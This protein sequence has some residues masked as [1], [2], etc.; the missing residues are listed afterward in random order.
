M[1][2]PQA[3][4]AARLDDL[5]TRIAHQDRMLAEMNEVITAQWDKID[6]LERQIARLR[7]ELQNMTPAREGPEPPPPHY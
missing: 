1:N 6:V 5:E 3:N 2:T 4:T 7:D